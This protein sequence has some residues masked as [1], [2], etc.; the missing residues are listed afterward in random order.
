MPSD[1]IS[2]TD[3][4][5]LLPVHQRRLVRSPSNR[6]L[7]RILA[8]IRAAQREAREWLSKH[9]TTCNCILCR[10][11][12]EPWGFRT[13]GDFMENDVR[14]LLWTLDNAEG[15]FF[16]QIPPAHGTFPTVTIE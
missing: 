12:G 10:E 7:Q 3:F 5:S 13:F 11:S 15:L 14:G 1:S 16:S 4:V 8:L 2:E 6:G 9:G